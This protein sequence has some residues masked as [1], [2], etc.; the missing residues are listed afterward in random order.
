MSNLLPV[1]ISIV[2]VNCP[3]S[4][5][6]VWFTF[7]IVTTLGDHSGYHMPFLHSP[8][9]HDYHHLKFNECFGTGAF[10]DKFHK[11][12]EKFEQSIHSI[13]YRTLF[14]FKAANELYP[15]EDM[16]NNDSKRD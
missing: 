14:T 5:S 10:L 4:A 8:E 12:S 1:V 16:N 13:R 2:A 7:A 11:T 3:L 9:F 15:D 6:W